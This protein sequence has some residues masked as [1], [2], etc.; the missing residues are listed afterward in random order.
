MNRLL[1]EQIETYLPN[2]LQSRDDF[3]A[4]LD[5]VNQ[6]YNNS[7]NKIAELQKVSSINSR[8]LFE[9]NKQLNQETRAQKKIISKL[10]NVINALKF[11]D[12][13]DDKNIIN[14]DSI[15]LVEFLEKHTNEI[16]EINRQKDTLVYNLQQ[17]N[18]ELNDY[19]HMISHD[20][21]SPLQS[22]DALTSWMHQDYED[23]LGDAG[24]EIIKLIRENVEKMDTLIQ[25]ILEYSTIGK[26]ERKQYS[27]D[28][29]I[30]IDEILLS[31]NNPKNMDIRINDT[32]PVVKGDLHRLELL[33]SHLI[34]NAIKFNDKGKKGVVEINYHED[35]NYWKFSVKD[36]GTGIESKY[37]EKVFVAF[38]KLEDD[39]KSTGIGLSIVKKIVDAYN[40]DIWIESTPNKHTIFNFTLKK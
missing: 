23:K 38:Q 27:V 24:K 8:E 32:L 5:A 11:Y 22:I 2:H 14:T 17:Q 39:Y 30:L 9:S 12:F 36:N 25:G 3:Q 33:F 4:F 28:L 16:L 37:F 15:K 13:D 19:A 18:Q 6:S 35:P 29:N 26:T 20:L 1:K 21:K 10:N 31:V 7:D 34:D 40:G